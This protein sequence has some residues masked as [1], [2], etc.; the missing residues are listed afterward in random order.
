MTASR[1]NYHRLKTRFAHT[2]QLIGIALL[3]LTACW[4]SVRDPIT[5]DVT[6]TRN[7]TLSATSIEILKTFDMP[8]SVTAYVP[9]QSPLRKQ[10]EFLIKRYQRNFRSTCLRK[11]Q[12]SA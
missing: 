2:L 10:I 3:A 12:L 8:L 5:R 7:H 11:A 1:F 4:W 9:P 6:D